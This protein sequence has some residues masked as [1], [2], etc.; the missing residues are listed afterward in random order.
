MSDPLGGNT[1][2]FGSG[3]WNIVS[4]G[5]GS[6]GNFKQGNTT[7]T[8]NS[9]GTYVLRWII[10]SGICEPSY[11]DIA[12][13]YFNTILSSNAGPGQSFCNTS[14]VTLNGN[15]PYPNFG[16][17]S[18][19]T[20]PNFPAIVNDTLQNTAITNMVPGLYIFK[21]SVS[22]GKC[23]PAEDTVK[24]VNYANPTTALVGDAQNICGTLTSQNLG[25]NIPT[26]G[27]GTWS[28]NSGGSGT[29]TAP[30]YGNTNFIA[31][32]YGSYVLRWTISNGLCNPSSADILVN[33]YYGIVANAGPDL[34][35]KTGTSTKLHGEV[36]NGSG[37]YLWNW[38]PSYMFQD[39]T[40]K[41]PTTFPINSST[42]FTMT[43]TDQASGCSTTDEINVSTGNIN[44]SPIAVADYDT[45]AMNTAKIIYVLAND[46]NTDGD[47][48]TIS[49]CNYPQHGLVIFNTDSTISYTPYSDYSG[50]DFFCY[51]I[52]DNGLPQKCS[53]T[54]VYVHVT[55]PNKENITIYNLLTPDGDGEND[56]W[57]VKGIEEY[58]DNNVIIFNRWGDKVKSYDRY[59]NTD[60]HWDGNNGKGDKMPDGAYYYILKINNLDVFTGWIYL[61]NRNN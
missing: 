17:W 50:D 6:F 21:W 58:P 49:L 1:P 18:L 8:G 51:R 15:D 55:T 19:V 20:G 33:Y 26:E 53:D 4:G 47:S 60:N 32:S 36:T 42:K 2:M 16:K 43:V 22:N 61:R 41:D 46:I 12:V 27:T 39:A 35:I 48:L 5:T 3:E 28:I 44:T 40:I 56:Y 57:I 59:N 38:E 7:F 24:I 30:L 54:L 45:T 13:T 52:C 14:I 31:N 37:N 34:T 25:G 23:H 29:F 10:K 11:A 9:Y